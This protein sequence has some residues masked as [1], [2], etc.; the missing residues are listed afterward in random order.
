MHE[1]TPTYWKNKAWLSSVWLYI[2]YLLTPVIF[3]IFGNSGG[4]V[5]FKRRFHYS[6][7]IV[8]NPLANSIKWRPPCLVSQTVKCIQKK[9][10]KLEGWAP[11]MTLPPRNMCNSKGSKQWDEFCSAPKLF[12]FSDL[13]QFCCYFGVVSLWL[14]FSRQRTA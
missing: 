7:N 3:V 12:V 8:F 5:Q 1:N 6:Y 2:L 4:G 14:C 9:T 11:V 13:F 10:W